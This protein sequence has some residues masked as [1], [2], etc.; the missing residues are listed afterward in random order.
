[1]T[2]AQYD[3]Q[4]KHKSG[5]AEYGVLAQMHTCIVETLRYLVTVDQLNPT[6]LLSAESLVRELL[7]LEAAV[8]RNPRQPDWEGLDVMTSAVLNSRGSLETP[9]FA[10]WVA[11]TQKDQQFVMKQ[12]RLLR[13]ERNQENTR[14]QKDK[15]KG[16]KGGKADGAEEE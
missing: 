7:R 8:S 15:N 4:W 1:M 5:V 13:E 14:R 10:S 11:T 2:L 12:T 6:E 3:I 16:G 9:H